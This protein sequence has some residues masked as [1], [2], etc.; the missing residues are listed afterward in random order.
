MQNYI[1]L[2]QNTSRKITTPQERFIEDMGLGYG[3]QKYFAEFL[4]TL[5]LI[6]PCSACPKDAVRHTA[7]VI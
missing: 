1:K 5:V 3:I 7:L 2:D 4:F 6:M